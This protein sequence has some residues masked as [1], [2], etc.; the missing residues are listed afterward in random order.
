MSKIEWIKDRVVVIL[1][2]VV[3]VKNLVSWVLVILSYF[4]KNLCGK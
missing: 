1:F 2:V 3:S 4:I